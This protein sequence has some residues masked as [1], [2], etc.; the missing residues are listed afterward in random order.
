MSNNSLHSSNGGIAR[1]IL[2]GLF[3]PPQFQ[4]PR[5]QALQPPDSYTLDVS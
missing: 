5:C 3:S 2:R 4:H 1:A